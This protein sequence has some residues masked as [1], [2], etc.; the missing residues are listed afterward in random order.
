M[1]AVTLDDQL[2]DQMV[3]ISDSYWVAWLGKRLVV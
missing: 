3:E 2:V 1:M